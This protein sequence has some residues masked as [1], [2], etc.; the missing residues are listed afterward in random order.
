[1]ALFRKEKFG[2]QKLHGDIFLTSP[3]SFASITAVLAALCMLALFFLFTV[4]YTRTERVPG[5]LVLTEGLVK[6]QAGR[7]GTLAD[8]HVKKG[9]SV[10]KGDALISMEVSRLTA[11]GIFVETAALQSLM[12][13]RRNLENQIA[14]AKKQLAS[15]IAR[16]QVEIAAATPAVSSLVSQ[17][18]LQG[19]AIEAARADFVSVQGILKQGYLSELEA[20]GYRK[21]W[22][23][24]QTE[25]KLIERELQG[26]RSKLKR[27]ET[28][29]RQLQDDTKARIA[30]QKEQL[31]ELDT[32][33]AELQGNEAYVLKAPM[34]GR[35]VSI[36]SGAVGQTIAPQQP[37]LTL[38]PENGRLTAELFVPSRAIGFVKEGQEARLLY[39]AFPYQRFGSQPSKIIE[40]TQK[41]LSP[42]ESNTP[43]K[44][45]E[46]SYR[47]TAALDSLT[48]DVGDKKVAL[49]SGMRLQA[50]IIQEKRFFLDWLLASIRAV[51]SGA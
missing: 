9:D 50:D 4:G 48:L 34:A 13:L 49:Q 12:A 39:A 24:R 7:L 25:G 15:K 16:I 3:V 6:I 36:A 40:L 29:L 33:K 11:D 14:L 35:V 17:L 37:I 46:P 43:F 47:V 22:L 23:K 18:G 19:E 45:D 27:L 31:K 2:E 8:L 26:A 20:E 5:Y 44:L 42:E 41:I 10:E 32:R 21:V 1:M 38:L 28:Q 30:R 51:R